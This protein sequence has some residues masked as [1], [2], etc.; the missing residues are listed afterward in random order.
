MG[1]DPWL[2]SR[3]S[4]PSLIHIRIFRFGSLRTMNGYTL[5]PSAF[6]FDR[7]WME[8]KLPTAECTR[9]NLSGINHAELKAQIPP[10]DS[11]AIA[12]LYPS[13]LSLYVFSTSGSTS[14]MRKR[15]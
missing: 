10:D 13:C 14:S 4:A 2:F 15:V 9:E 7:H 11:P 3:S 12:R 6:S 5:P 8:V 1:H